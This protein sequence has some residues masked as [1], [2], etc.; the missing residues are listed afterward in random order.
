MTQ[1]SRAQPVAAPAATGGR[2]SRHAPALRTAP[3]LATINGHPATGLPA[4]AEVLTADGVWRAEDLRPGQRIITR[5]RGFR[6]L[7]GTSQRDAKVDLV[8]V[9]ADAFGPGCPEV[10]LSLPAS[11]PI[12]LRAARATGCPHLAQQMVPLGRLMD[13]ARIRP[14]APAAPQRIVTLS[15]DAPHVIYAAGL[16]LLADVAAAFAQG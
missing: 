7:H 10:A 13:G 16:E 5:D 1:V 14:A 12:L 15:F 6:P 11:Q 8:T 3:T 9:E 4:C 2:S